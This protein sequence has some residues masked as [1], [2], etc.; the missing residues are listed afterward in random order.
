MECVENLQTPIC[1]TCKNPIDLNGETKVTLPRNNWLIR[2]L[3]ASQ[4]KKA[5][6]NSTSKVSSGAPK[7]KPAGQRV[8]FKQLDKACGRLNVSLQT[9][10]VPR[11]EQQ[12]L[13]ERRQE[14][15]F[16]L[17]LSRICRE[18]KAQNATFD[19]K[20]FV[21]QGLISKFGEAKAKCILHEVY[22]RIQVMRDRAISGV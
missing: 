17:N 20:R 15:M 3:V 6:H 21:T 7:V 2:C 4:S 19:S 18:R 11:A 12:R 9:P 14:R 5:M 10:S 13:E 22:G 16:L 1:P 8:L